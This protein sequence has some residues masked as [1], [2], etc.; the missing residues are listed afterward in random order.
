MNNFQFLEFWLYEWSIFSSISSCGSVVTESTCFTL[1][2]Y[3]EVANCCGILCKYM[4]LLESTALQFSTQ[5]VSITVTTYC[6]NMIT[7][8]DSL[9]S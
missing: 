5:R 8:L 3:T 2:S 6:A 7:R 4:G 9:S 1:G